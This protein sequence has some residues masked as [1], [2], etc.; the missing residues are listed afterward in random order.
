MKAAPSKT[1]VRK[2]ARVFLVCLS[3]QAQA[4]PASAGACAGFPQLYGQLFEDAQ[5][6]LPDTK[7]FVDAIPHQPPAG[8]AAE[9]ANA[10]GLPGFDLHAFLAERF[11]LPRPPGNYRTDPRHDVRQ[12]IDALWHVLERE[13]VAAD[14]RTSLLPLPY[15]YV[16]PGGRFDEIY[17]WDSYF[18]MLGLEESGRHD[19]VAGM[20]KNFAWL[21]D[22]YGHV[23]NGNRTYYLSRSQPPFFAAMVNLLAERE[24]PSVLANHLPQLAAEYD[25]WMEGSSGL[26]PGQAHRRVV[27]LADGSLLNRYWDDCDTPREESY[28]A[29]VATALA[30]DRPTAEVYRNLRAGAESGWDYSSRWLADGRTLATIRTVDIVPPDL[31]SLIYHLE[32]T[33]A[34]AYAV[35]RRPD[36]AERLQERA[37]AR[38]AAMHRHLWN[39]EKGVFAD[40]LWREGRS[41]GGITAATLYPLFFGIA[42]PEQAERIAQQV[43]SSLLQPHGLAATTVRTGQ[44]WDFPNGWAPLQWIAV[45]GLS[46]YGQ[47]ELAA[48]IARRWIRRN[49]AVYAATGKL[50]EKYDVTGSDAAG[51]GEYALQDGFGWTNGVLRKLIACYPDAAQTAP[52]TTAAGKPDTRPR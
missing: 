51:G 16:V 44:Q 22:R 14:A 11:T 45:K 43:R 41:T 5:R 1:S 30:S 23:P 4:G 24:G 42:D 36:E 32:L 29:D 8:I 40:F 28:G 37:A 13:P 15:P 27:R 38:K 49:I 10:R 33:L 9:Y 12:H 20:V 48:S 52:G 18:T 26:A 47:R 6:V 35:A 17:Y 34:H 7:A 3:L 21:I 25:F 39:A 2:W 50:V 31:N 19:L 46:D